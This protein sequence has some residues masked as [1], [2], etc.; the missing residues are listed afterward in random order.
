MCFSW[1]PTKTGWQL[2]NKLGYPSGVSFLELIPFLV[3]IEGTREGTVLF[4]GVSEKQ[5]CP[6][7]GVPFEG[8]PCG[9]LRANFSGVC[10]RLGTLFGIPGLRDVLT[11][12]S[13]AC[14]GTISFGGVSFL[15]YRPQQGYT[16]TISSV[17]LRMYSGGKFHTTCEPRS[18]E[19][20][21]E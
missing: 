21:K 17:C 10:L 11:C 13:N 12:S 6:Y 18:N 3:G 5:T 9:G 15:F 7:M 8:T 16:Q 1:K 20:S 19:V 2:Q 14:V 4:W